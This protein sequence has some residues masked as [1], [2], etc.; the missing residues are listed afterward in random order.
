MIETAVVGCGGIGRK[1]ALAW[2][3][4]KG[5]DIKY[6]VDVDKNLAQQLATEVGG[7]AVT[8]IDNI[9]ETVKIVSV[10][11]FPSSHYDVVKKLLEMNKHVF[12]EKP[13]T[14]NYEEGKQVEKISQEKRLKLGVGFKMRYEPLFKKAKELIVRLGKIYQVQTGK[15]QPYPD[16]S[17]MSETGVFFE[18]SIHDFDLVHFIVNT[19]PVEVLDVQ[20]S[21]KLGWEKPDGFQVHIKYEQD[22]LGSLC[23]LYVK[24]IKWTGRDFYMWIAGEN[25]YLQIDRGDR[26]VLHTDEIEMFQVSQNPDTFKLQLEDFLNCVINNTDVPVSANDGN[27]ATWVVCECEKNIKKK[28]SS[29]KGEVRDNAK[30]NRQ[31]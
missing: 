19:K 1:H 25:G 12:C 10:A 8:N 30:V 17:W 2:K 9:S 3:E 6:C 21:M 26:L 28:N 7:I 14:M 4:I 31:N 18:L 20:Y 27:L 16:K 11:T 24:N 22:I 23:G 5:V 15:I 29:N 13:L